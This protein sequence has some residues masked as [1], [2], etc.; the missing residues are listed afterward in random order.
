MDYM[1]Q[2]ARKSTPFNETSRRTD[3]VALPPE[4]QRIIA[5]ALLSEFLDMRDEIFRLNQ[6]FQDVDLHLGTFSG[7]NDHLLLFRRNGMTEDENVIPA[8]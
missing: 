8:R 4:P 5:L 7:F 1:P 3:L 2:S 6:S